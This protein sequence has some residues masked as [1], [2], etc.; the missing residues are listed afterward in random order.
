MMDGWRIIWEREV[1]GS[2]PATPIFTSTPM[3]SGV[4]LSIGET[5]RTVPRL[6]DSG[7]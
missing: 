2:I 4:A 5:S 1:A 3:G 6:I 7:A